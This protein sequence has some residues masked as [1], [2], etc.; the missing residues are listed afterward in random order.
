MRK[1][2]LNVFITFSIAFLAHLI[3]NYSFYKWLLPDSIFWILFLGV[4]IIIFINKLMIFKTQSYIGTIFALIIGARIANLIM[5]N[6]IIA[7]DA[8]I[9]IDEEAVTMFII[10]LFHILIYSMFHIFFYHCTKIT[11]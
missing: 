10:V 1:Q 5:I 6:F 2:F 7:P 9:Q 4:P 3:I 8:I 11:Q